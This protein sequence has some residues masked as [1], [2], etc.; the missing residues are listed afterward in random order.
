VSS[1]VLT[2]EE[3]ERQEQQTGASRNGGA[4]EENATEHQLANLLK[5]QLPPLRCVGSDWYIYDKGVW[6]RQTSDIFRPQALGIQNPLARTHRKATNILSHLES[7]AQ[8]SESEF[9]SFHRFDGDA[10]LINCANGVLRVT[11]AGVEILEHSADYLF[12]SQVAAS[13]NPEAAAPT[14]ERVLQEA[15]PD[16]KDLDLFR[17]LWGTRFFQI[18][19][20]KLC[21]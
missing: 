9:Q 6:K 14:F 13:F 21:W 18:A 10:I 4:L 20:M 12:T 15:L 8:V 19:A 11:A 1:Q 7:E 16:N 2:P 3:L 17:Y 5:T